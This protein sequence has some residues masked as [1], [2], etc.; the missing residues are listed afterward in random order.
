[1]LSREEVSEARAYYDARRSPPRL[2][3]Q[4]GQ[5]ATED[6]SGRAQVKSGPRMIDGPQPY[7]A[8][9]RDTGSREVALRFITH[10]S[11]VDRRG[12]AYQPAPNLSHLEHAS[13]A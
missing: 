5:G 3:R 9:S 8:L 1:L 13:T 10:A 11:G 12:A 6:L 7:E 2:A 4:L